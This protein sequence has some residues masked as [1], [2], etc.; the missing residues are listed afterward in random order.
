MARPQNM[1]EVKRQIE[2][3]L[4]GHTAPGSRRKVTE[5][6]TALSTD[7]LPAEEVSSGGSITVPAVL[8]SVAGAVGG[9]AIQ[10][11]TAEQV[12]RA[13][14]TTATDIER[15]AEVLLKVATG[16]AEE[17]HQLA[18]LLRKH[19]QLLAN[20]IEEFTAMTQRVALKMRDARADVM[21]SS[22]NGTFKVP[23][24]VPNEL[25]SLRIDK[26]EE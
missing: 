9:G 7:T 13:C 24:I 2:Q 18:E 17:S 23:G 15:A 5:N 25:V 22:E 19:G 3:V 1:D 20:R 8:T 11:G 6:I 21:G 12:T 26:P 16:I 4:V 14:D 10:D